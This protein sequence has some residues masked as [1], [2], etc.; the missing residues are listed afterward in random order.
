MLKLRTL[1][2]LCSVVL[3]TVTLAPAR[4]QVTPNTS[5]ARTRKS[6][7]RVRRRVRP[8]RPQIISAAE[9]E[10]TRK[11]TLRGT[12][13]STEGGSFTLRDARG[14]D[15]VVLL[16]PET[17]YRIRKRPVGL[18]P[19]DPG[20]L[21]RPGSK[22]TVEGLLNSSYRMKANLIIAKSD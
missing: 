22:V 1:V 3:M 8:A 13:I 4:Q 2:A 21:I 12:I 20:D 5:P 15:T 16:F 19:A 6:S 7:R 10:Y 14:L 17:L 9:D 11:E 18:V